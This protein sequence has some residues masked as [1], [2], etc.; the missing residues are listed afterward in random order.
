MVAPNYLYA[1]LN[2]H[3]KFDKQCRGWTETSFAE[4]AEFP[5]FGEALPRW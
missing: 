5:R 4:Q 2:V 3:P 1:P